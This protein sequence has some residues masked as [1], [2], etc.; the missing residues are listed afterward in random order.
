[1]GFRVVL[2]PPA[3]CRLASF[4]VTL[5]TTVSIAPSI[6]LDAAFLRTPSVAVRIGKSPGIGT[7]QILIFFGCGMGT[8]SLSACPGIATGREMAM[9]L[10]QGLLVVVV[11]FHD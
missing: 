10:V 5:S 8:G 3:C 11:A 7:I 4:S 2:R 9:A 6:A 1:M